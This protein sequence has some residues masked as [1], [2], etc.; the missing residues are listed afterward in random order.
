MILILICPYPTFHNP[1]PLLYFI[2]G[3]K[4][5]KIHG[6]G[7]SKQKKKEWGGIFCHLSWESHTSLCLPSHLFS[8]WN[9]WLQTSLGLLCIVIC[10]TCCCSVAKL[11]LILCDPIDW[12][13]TKLPCPLPS[14]RVC[15]NSCPL[16]QWCHPTISSC[17]QSFLTSGS[18]PMS[19]PLGHLVAV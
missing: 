8:S 12:K 15:S 13:H 10:L 19:R 9:L 4:K 1:L 3:L 14:P 7:F 11:C 18:F 17:P 5:K 16:S 2:Q 6:D